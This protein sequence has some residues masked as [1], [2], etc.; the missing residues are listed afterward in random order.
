MALEQV[1]APVAT[2]PLTLAS[3]T[4]NIARQSGAVSNETDRYTDVHVGGK[5][6]TGTSPTAGSPI[7]I[8]LY[9]SWD[10]VRFTGSVGG[11]EGGFNG[12]GTRVPVAHTIRVDATSNK[13][14]EWGPISLKKFFKQMPRKWGVVIYNG[15][16][17]ALNATAGNHEVKATGINSST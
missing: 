13:T 7:T 16:G 2:I 5:V 15:T 12:N 3:L 4:H 17:V 10:G 11:L 9:A 1:Y 14:Y 6:T 8:F